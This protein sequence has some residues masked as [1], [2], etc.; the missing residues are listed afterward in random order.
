MSSALCISKRLTVTVNTLHKPKKITL[1][2]FAEKV[3]YVSSVYAPS[4]PALISG[5]S[6]KNKA[7]STPP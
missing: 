3:R 2:S 7:T 5:F 4:G 6:I 1:S